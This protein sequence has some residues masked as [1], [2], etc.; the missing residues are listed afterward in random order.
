L[1]GG[2]G[3]GS[4]LHVELVRTRA[5]TSPPEEATKKTQI[6]IMIGK[7]VFDYYSSAVC[8]FA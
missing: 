1:G 2:G 7:V 4:P 3:G 8:C 5:G 6:A